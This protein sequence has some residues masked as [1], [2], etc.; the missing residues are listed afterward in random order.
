MFLLTKVF[1]LRDKANPDNEKPFLEHLDDLRVMITRSLV[2]LMIATVGCFMLQDKLMTLLRKPIDEVQEIHSV[3]LLPSTITPDQWEMAKKVE[4]ASQ[5]FEG[6]H[7]AIYLAEFD[8]ATLHNVELVRLLRA[9]ASFP[10]KKDDAERIKRQETLLAKLAQP[11]DAKVV[12]DMMSKGASPELD[13]RGNLKM[14]STLKPTESFML[15]MK[16]AFFAGIV[17]SFPFLLLFILQFVLPGLHEHEQKVL[18]PALGI[19]F[20]LFLFGVCF[21]YL[22]VLPRALTFFYEWSTQMG[23]SN[24]WRI[25]EYV[26]FAT[27]FTLLFGLSFELP[28]VVMVFVK[29]GLLTYETMRKTRSYAILTI[30]VVAAIITPTPDAFTLCLMAGPMCILYEVCIWLA[31]FDEKKRLAREAEEERQR[32]EEDRERLERL[33]KDEKEKEAEA[34]DKPASTT[35]ANTAAAVAAAASV[36]ALPIPDSLTG[37]GEGNG[38]RSDSDANSLTAEE[39]TYASQTGHGDPAGDHPHEGGEEEDRSDHTQVQHPQPRAATGTEPW[40]PSANE[41]GWQAGK[42]SQAE[43]ETNSPSP[44][45]DSGTT[46]PANG[47]HKPSALTDH[48][49]DIPEVPEGDGDLDDTPPQS[50][51][52]EEARRMSNLGGESDR[53]R[54]DDGKDPEKK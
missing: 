48:L 24:D 23:V 53:D 16:L 42:D 39:K 19:G 1:Q 44:A 37:H 50:I 10:G 51:P 41:E 4:H 14:L 38:A 7:R 11:D 12:A 3:K 36:A 34:G 18:W 52:G 6:Q 40:D 29:I 35:D 27:Q 47:E 15:S 54:Q 13:E 31:Y 26:T 9:I 2:V 21:A 20:G 46:T 33:L 45:A 5:S 17:V 43:A 32:G 22:F 49:G 8:A 25:G 28:V 30:F